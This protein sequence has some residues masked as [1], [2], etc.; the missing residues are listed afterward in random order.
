MTE[1]QKHI[2]MLKQKCREQDEQYKETVKQCEKINRRT[3]LM[4]ELGFLLWIA[5]IIFIVVWSV[6]L[7]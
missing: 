7:R 4:L 6:F 3:D 2:E 5:S 1:I